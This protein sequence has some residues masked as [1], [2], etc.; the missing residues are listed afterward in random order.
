M[1]LKIYIDLKNQE[2]QLPINYNHIL[3]G[4]IYTS[5]SNDQKYQKLLHNFGIT[6]IYNFKLFTFGSLCGK[7]YVENKKITFTEKIFWEI[8]S[9]D[10]YFIILL[11][12]YF[13]ANGIT[14]GARTI[15]PNL[16]IENKIIREES[17]TVKINSPICVA[18]RCED[19]KVNY[20]SPRDNIFEEYINNNFI[21][22]YSSYYNVEPNTNLEITNI[23]LSHK[24]KFVT[25][26]KGIYITAWKGK[27]ILTGSPDYLTFLYNSGLGSKNSQ[28]FGLFEIIE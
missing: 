23:E 8:R 24:D 22:K 25:T 15:F 17:I 16:N 1:Q 14:F 28:G 4:I 27:Y 7:H 10:S 6:E 3:Q 13:K 9:V 12:E 19:N 5:L 20:L 2:L 18:Q 11:Y 26:L 21:K